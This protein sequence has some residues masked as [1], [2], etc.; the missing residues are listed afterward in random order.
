MLELTVPEILRK[1]AAVVRLGWCQFTRDNSFKEHCALGA[2]EVA[3]NHHRAED[4]PKVLAALVAVLPIPESET[5][6]NWIIANWNN[7]PGRTAKEVA[8]KME[9]AAAKFEANG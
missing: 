6:H 9:L 5:R 7:A 2:I 4:Y 1:A 8:E 3:T